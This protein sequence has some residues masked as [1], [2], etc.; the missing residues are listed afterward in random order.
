M[1]GSAAFWDRIAA[2]YA[3]KPVADEAAYQRKQ[4]RSMMLKNYSVEH[5]ADSLQITLPESIEKLRAYIEQE[6][7]NVPD[8]AVFEIDFHQP[9]FNRLRSERKLIADQKNQPAFTILHD[10]TLK[11]IAYYLPQTVDD[12]L[13]ISG[14]SEGKIKRGCLGIRSK[15]GLP[16][17]CQKTFEARR[18]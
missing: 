16:R 1:T 7:K 14:I 8:A 17:R 15:P 4:I 3:R 11:A 5:I 2:R 6:K 18:P 9:V 12:F 13:Q 10:R